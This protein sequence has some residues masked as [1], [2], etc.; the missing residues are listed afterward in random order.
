MSESN[1]ENV[2]A[3]LSFIHLL[4]AQYITH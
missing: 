3:E 2:I 1:A 4:N